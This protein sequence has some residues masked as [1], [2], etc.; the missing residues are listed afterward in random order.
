M[1]NYVFVGYYGSGKTEM[2]VNFAYARKQAEQ[3]VALVDLDIVN[4]Y[5]RSRELKEK[6]AEDG[7]D[8]IVS[9]GKLALADLPALTPAI[10]GVLSQPQLPVIWDVGGDEVGATALGR[11][12][13]QIEASSYQLY[14]VVN[15]FRPFTRKPAEILKVKEEIERA[16]RLKIT[17]FVANPNLGEATTVQQVFEG[18][19]LVEEAAI[20][21]GIPLAWVGVLPGLLPEVSELLPGRNFLTLERFMLTPWQRDQQTFNTD[22]RTMFKPGNR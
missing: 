7:I 14:L 6:L 15:T 1:K 20:L 5:F 2:A 8:V 10:Y 9:E 19:L 17:H 3:R 16:A 13:A 12:A 4:L 18:T 11:F 21:A 22:P